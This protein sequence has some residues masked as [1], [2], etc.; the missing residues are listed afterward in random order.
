MI[1]K[2]CILVYRWPQSLVQIDQF[3]NSERC[4]SL[5]QA[6]PATAAPDLENLPVVKAENKEELERLAVSD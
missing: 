2:V 3:L 6:V 5:F 4:N 1:H